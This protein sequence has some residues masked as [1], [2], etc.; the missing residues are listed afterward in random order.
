[1]CNIVHDEN[2]RLVLIIQC[3]SLKLTKTTHPPNH[4]VWV[5]ANLLVKAD[6]Q[7]FIIKTWILYINCHVLG[8]FLTIKYLCGMV[9]TVTLSPAN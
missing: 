5:K 7:P 8:Y 3:T 1:M 2:T 6:K 4:I 9:Q